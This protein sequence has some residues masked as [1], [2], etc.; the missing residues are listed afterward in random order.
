MTT[1]QDAEDGVR[2]YQTGDMLTVADSNQSNVEDLF[3]PLQQA[4]EILTV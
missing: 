1:L 2:N 3:A 4:T